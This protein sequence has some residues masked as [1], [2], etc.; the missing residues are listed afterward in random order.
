VAGT[1]PDDLQL[2]A[3]EFLDAV[4]EALDTIPTYN[5]SL[6]GAPERKFVTFGT[7]ALDCC[8]QLSVH[9]GILS[10]GSSAPTVPKAS[11]ARINRVQ[12]IATFTR[13]VPSPDMTNPPPAVEIEAA[14]AQI[15]ADKWAVWNHIYNLI[16]ADM[17]FDK[18]CDVIWGP[19]APLQ[20]SGGCGGSTLS[21]QV[22]YDGYEEVQ[23][24]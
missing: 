6:E 19:L 9:V 18:C 20:P 11:I 4:E 15:N 21:M 14:A 1:G 22:C 24:T 12:L 5:A 8:E 17:L 16:N 13:C 23:G 2:L 3:Q 10:E 7:P